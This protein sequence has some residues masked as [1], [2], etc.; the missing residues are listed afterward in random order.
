MLEIEFM[1]WHSRRS[2]DH[3]G[4]S[5]LSSAQTSKTPAF[6][7]NLYRERLSCVRFH[8]SVAVLQTQLLPHC[9]AHIGPTRSLET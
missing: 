4:P 7:S 9:S 6:S 3:R 8:D 2:Y 1:S 5:S